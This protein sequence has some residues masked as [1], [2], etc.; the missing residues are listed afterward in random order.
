MMKKPRRKID[1][2][3]KAR[4][5]LEALRE[6]ATVTDLAVRY[7]VH[8]NQIYAWKKQL[9]DNAARA[10]DPGVG[11]DAE[12]VRERE[13]EHL[14]AKIGQLMYR[15][16]FFGH[17]A[18]LCGLVRGD[19]CGHPVPPCFGGASVA[20]LFQEPVLVVVRPDGGADLLDVLED[21]SENDLLLSVRMKR[22]ATP[23]VSGSRTKAKLDAMRKNLSWFWKCSDICRGRDA[24][25]PRARHPRGRIR[26]PGRR[27]APAP[28]RR[29]NGFHVWQRASRGPRRSS[30]R[31]R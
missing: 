10:F 14:H 13:V 2:A 8:P 29:H 22:S 4:I 5:A 9:L 7:E 20:V 24:T 6:Q 15:A 11:V 31:R 16:R 30:A 28:Q 21:T 25:A 17:N 18:A 26:T 3:L 19:G 23:L 12:H 27:P 1:A